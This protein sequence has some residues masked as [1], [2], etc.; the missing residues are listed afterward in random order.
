MMSEWHLSII[1][2][3]LNEESCIER[4]LQRLIPLRR[5][6]HEVILVDGGSSDRTAAIG[7]RLVDRVLSCTPGRALQMNHGAAH[8]RGRLLLFLHADTL[9]PADADIYLQQ[10]LPDNEL[11]WGRFDVRLSGAHPVLRIVETSMNI[12]SRVSGIATGDQAMFVTRELFEKIGGFS[13]IEIME[14]IDLSRRLL[15]MRKPLCLTRRVE[16]SSRRWERAGIYATIL[17]MWLLRF[18]Y[19][20]GVPPSRLARYYD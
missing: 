10:Q 9:L 11:A 2:P 7:G 18:A 5:R 19:W 3:A 20:I 14:D 13:A 12:R 15:Q 8:A 16:T 1:V 17:R 6:G 4:T